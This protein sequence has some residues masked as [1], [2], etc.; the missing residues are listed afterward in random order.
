MKIYTTAVLLT[1]A[2][3]AASAR[4]YHVSVSGD[5]LHEGTA[6][7]P[8]QTIS[9]AASRAQAGDVITVHQGVYRERINPPRGGDSG[10]NRIVYRS[11]PG[12][13]A[14]IK[15]SEAIKGWV[16][17]QNDTWKVTVP[18]HFFGDFN[19]YSDTIHGDWFS[20]KGRDHHTGAVY[21][22]G[23]WLTEAVTLENVLNPVGDGSDTRLWFAQVDPS[24]T[25]I[26][27]QFRG[28]EPNEAE[29]EINVRQ[30][31]FYPGKP[32]VNYI[33]VRGL[34]M[35]HAA[36]PWAPPTAEQIGL[37]GT[38]WSKGW[39]IEDCDI[40]YSTCVGIALGKHGDQWDNTSQNTAEGYVKTIERA[41]E[42][43]WSKENIGHHIVRHNQ[44]S[45]CEQAGVVGSLAQCSAR[46]PATSFT[47]STSDNSLRAPRWPG[48]RSMLQSTLRSAEI[49][50]IERAAGFGSIG[51]PRERV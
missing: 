12:D 14:V 43:G 45:H 38:H 44:I 49:T 26:W 16:K 8:V 41:I 15:G 3:T 46:S 6:E 48:S 31:V 23:H 33:T 20:P 2:V 22:N 18:N 51:W 25:T 29:V 19:P 32:G 17:V 35:M 37:I 34:T 21:L 10:E 4:E 13:T 24:N 30:T 27:A 9:A 11:A 50:S 40:R 39:I 47:T 1:V 7:S 36:T 5:D 28:V 42:N